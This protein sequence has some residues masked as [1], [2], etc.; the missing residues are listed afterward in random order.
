MVQDELSDGL[1]QI[2]NRRW[3][4]SRAGMGLGGDAGRDDLVGQAEL[5]PGDT[6]LRMTH[7][8]FHRPQLRRAEMLDP[9][10]V[11]GPEVSA[12]AGSLKLSAVIDWIGGNPLSAPAMWKNNLNGTKIE[13]LRGSGSVAACVTLF[14]SPSC[15]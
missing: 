1:L 8:V 9:A 11:R 6:G 3:P 2:V 10:P 12:T 15:S 14:C 4:W 7:A 5:G 13:L